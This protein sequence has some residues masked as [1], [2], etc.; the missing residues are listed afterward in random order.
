MI[1]LLNHILIIVYNFSTDNAD[2]GRKSS[3]ES[4]DKSCAMA[5]VTRVTWNVAKKYDFT[6]GKNLD[7]LRK[8]TFL[9]G[10]FKSALQGG[11]WWSTS[12]MFTLLKGNNLTV[13]YKLIKM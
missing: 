9:C 4:T 6:Y 13:N 10:G 7:E 12:E 8:F 11:G 1:K 3:L 5:F 2:D